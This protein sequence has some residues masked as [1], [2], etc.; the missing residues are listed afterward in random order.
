MRQK[1]IT[2]RVIFQTNILKDNDIFNKPS[3][4]CEQVYKERLRDF[5]MNCD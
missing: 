1:Y 3:F 5:I 4:V 2:K